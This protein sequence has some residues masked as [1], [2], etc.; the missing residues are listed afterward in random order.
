[1]TAFELLDYCLTKR[2]ECEFFGLDRFLSLTRKQP[3]TTVATA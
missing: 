2:R 3:S 1:M